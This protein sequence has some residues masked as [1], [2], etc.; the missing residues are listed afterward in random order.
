MAPKG[1]ALASRCGR[2][3][4]KPQHIIFLVTALIFVLLVIWTWRVLLPVENKE[5]LVI[6][7][8]TSV[9]LPPLQQN[10]VFTK[11]ASAQ[12]RLPREFV[13]HDSEKP[14]EV[15]YDAEGREI[16]ENVID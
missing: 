7:K 6:P 3:D 14:A 2:V 1:V 15:L 4:M 13:S 5:D 9:E 10:I 11:P 16:P 12:K 8:V